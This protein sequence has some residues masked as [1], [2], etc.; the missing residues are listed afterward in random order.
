MKHALLK[1]LSALWGTGDIS[2]SLRYGDADLI[3]DTPLI[4]DRIATAAK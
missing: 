4:L 1:Y 3:S 2:S